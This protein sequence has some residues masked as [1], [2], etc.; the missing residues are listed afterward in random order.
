MY[1]IHLEKHF[2]SSAKKLEK[3]VKKELGRNLLLLKQ[4]PT[5]SHL[6]LKPLH[7]HLGGFYS[8]RVKEYRVIVE[9]L[10]EKRIRI[11][12]IDKRDKIYKK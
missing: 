12:E 2:L 9:F 8:F 10:K 5:H 7:G 11:L 6:R 4:D 3:E 1:T